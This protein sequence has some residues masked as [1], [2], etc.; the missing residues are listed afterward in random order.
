MKKRIHFYITKKEIKGYELTNLL[1][2]IGG[3]Q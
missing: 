1:R 3:A 2:S